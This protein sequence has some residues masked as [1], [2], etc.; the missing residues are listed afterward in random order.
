ME[1]ARTT[2]Q[3]SD[4]VQLVCPCDFADGVYSMRL[5]IVVVKYRPA[6]L[7]LLNSS[8]VGCQLH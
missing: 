5:E 7:E 1:N 2:C 8:Q 3:Y 6:K 4:I